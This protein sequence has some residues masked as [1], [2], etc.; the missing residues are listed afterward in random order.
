MLKVNHPR[1]LL[2]FSV[3]LL[4]VLGC[5]ALPA[6]WATPQALAAPQPDPIPRRW[7]LQIEPGPLRVA[8]VEVPG[9]DNRTFFYFTYKV[10]N[11]SGGNRAGANQDP[12]LAPVFELYTD[13]GEI[14]RSGRGVPAPVVT[15]LLNRLENPLL[16]NEIKIQGTIK[17]GKQHAREGLVVWPANSMKVD[18]VVIFAAGFSGE[19]KAVVR[20]DTGQTVVLRKTLM[21]RHR[22]PGELDPTSSAPLRRSV[23]RWILR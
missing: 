6:F 16:Q 21:I 22:V 7:E 4:T 12:Y 2:I 17:P 18:E 1:R 5:I 14:I 8:T 23:Q 9:A 13:D 10:T 15:E 19:T 3:G 20:P 11:L